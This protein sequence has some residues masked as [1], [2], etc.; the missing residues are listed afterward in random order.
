MRC[1]SGHG[2]GIGIYPDEG[3]GS[4][5]SSTSDPSEL[6]AISA[7]SFFDDALEALGRGDANAQSLQ[8]L[9][10]KR[11]I[12]RLIPFV[13]AGLCVEFDYPTW[14]ALLAQIAERNGLG[15]EVEA[16]I[17]ARDFEA[18]AEQIEER[19]PGALARELEEAFDPAK[20][21]RPITKGAVHQIA[22]LASSFVLTTNFDVVLEAAFADAGRPFEGVY[23]GSDIV[24]ASQTV[25]DS[26][27]VLLKLHG[28]YDSADKRVLTLTE[29]QR[30][31]GPDTKA[32]DRSLG[33]PSVLGLAM[34]NGP[35]LFV[36]CSLQTDRTTRV[37]KELTERLG[38]L[39]HFAVLPQSQDTPKRC[40]ELQN[41]KIY[42]LF[43]RGEEYERVDRFLELIA[44]HV[45]R[46]EGA[47]RAQQPLAEPP[48]VRSNREALADAVQTLPAA[49]PQRSKPRRRIMWAGVAAALALIGGWAFLHDWRGD[50]FASL[51][52]A[53]AESAAAAQFRQDAL[54]AGYLDAEVLHSWFVSFMEEHWIPR[55]V[56]VET[57]ERKRAS[58]EPGDL[59]IGI[60]DRSPPDASVWNVDAGLFSEGIRSPAISPTLSIRSRGLEPALGPHRDNAGGLSSVGWATVL[61][62]YAGSYTGPLAEWICRNFAPTRAPFIEGRQLTDSFE[63][64][65]LQPPSGCPPLTFLALKDDRKL[66]PAARFRTRLGLPG[67]SSTQ[68]ANE[69]TYVHVTQTAANSR[70]RPERVSLLWLKRASPHAPESSP[71]PSTGAAAVQLD[72]D[73]WNFPKQPRLGFVEIPDDGEFKMGS[74]P[75]RDSAAKLD[76]RPQHPLRLPRFFIGRYEVTIGQYKRFLDANPKYF[77]ALEGEDRLAVSEVSWPEALAYTRWIDARLREEDHPF[78]ADVRSILTTSAEGCRVTLPSEAEWEKA[79]R[80]ADGRIFPWGDAADVSRGNF[81][82]QGNETVKPVGSYLSGRSPYGVFEISGNLWEWTCSLSA[83]GPGAPEFK[84]PFRPDD[85]RREDLAADGVR[86]I[87]GGSFGNGIEQARAAARL[88]YNSERGNAG[89]AQGFRLAISCSNR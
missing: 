81:A 46:D 86:I 22:R 42:P 43:F 51:K 61:G 5:L 78:S 38:G 64:L 72:P 27:R 44:N 3:C 19:V 89:A 40:Q 45:H 79:A 35:V 37:I 4:G 15:P 70:S 75:S 32:I 1:A 36:G 87:K 34:G 23:A 13:G 53:D 17:R 54:A 49:S 55:Q 9:E 20:I 65:R 14:S 69:A 28:T 6:E 18:A 8:F 26:Q 83:P 2:Q 24:N 77:R 76:E 29:Y 12:W 39:T 7:V 11:R 48:S 62:V 50:P 71:T 47:G 41:W 82:A 10:E 25:H 56:L 59:A 30:E 84:Y 52:T 68:P 33:L 85:P 73:V 74:D 57:L 31:Y 60:W 66:T 58:D 67:V 80:G 21:H 88:P 16:D 63:S